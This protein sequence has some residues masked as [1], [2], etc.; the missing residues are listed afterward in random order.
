MAEQ[1]RDRIKLP[2]MVLGLVVRLAE[3]HDAALGE[4]YGSVASLFV[5]TRANPFR[6]RHAVCGL[7][8]KWPR[9]V[10]L[11][12]V[13]GRLRR[14]KVVH[15]DGTQDPI[16]GS[17]DSSDFLRFRDRWLEL[18]PSPPYRLRLIAE[19]DSWT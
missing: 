4:R 17:D 8:C 19:A 1:R 11:L 18:S 9:M 3:Q 12:R 5:A 2:A 16:W 15:R 7:R 10:S 6:R 13:L 14:L